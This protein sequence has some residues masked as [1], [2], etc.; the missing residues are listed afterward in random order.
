MTIAVNKFLKTFHR[1]LTN[2]RVILFC[3]LI[4]SGIDLG[5]YLLQVM[6][7]IIV[8]NNLTFDKKLLNSTLLI[9]SL[10]IL[11]FILT[12]N[13]IVL[14]YIGLV[15][16]NFILYNASK[17]FFLKNYNIKSIVDFVFIIHVIVILLS[18]FVPPINKLLSLGT[19][20]SIR[21]AGLIRGY[22]FVP[23]VCG[24]FI[25]CEFRYIKYKIDFAFG[26]KLILSLI[27]TLLSGR[28][29]LVVF[30]FIFMY[31]LFSKFTLAKLFTLLSIISLGLIV[32]NERLQFTYTTIVNIID[33]SVN[34]DY[35]VFKQ[36]EGEND[37]FYA[38]SPITWFDEFK[39]P[40]AEPFK[41]LWPQNIVTIIDT[42]VSYIFSNL[43]FLCGLGLYVYSLKFFKVNN[44]I[45]YT[46]FILFLIVDFKFRSMFVVLPMFWLY[47]NLFK[48]Q[49]KENLDYKISLV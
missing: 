7:F 35:D 13:V 17:H 39:K 12:F 33:F 9:L 22:D 49:Y 19:K 18:F 41:Y 37:G 5:A 11:V 26:L 29:G 28:F 4:T 25:I 10:L 20:D 27:V 16:F 30:A 1:F 23:F 44:K 40:F 15:C 14:K 21:Y 36:I 46:M 47:L 45:F 24:T 43:G 34:N 3:L 31:I 48:I 2:W 38:G 6:L 42:G 8:L 32:F